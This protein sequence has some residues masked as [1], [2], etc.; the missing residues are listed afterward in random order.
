M[1][2]A[3][4]HWDVSRKRAVVDAVR[5][6]KP[7]FSPA[8]VVK[9]CADLLKPYRLSRVKGDRYGGE[10]PREAFREHRIEYYL[11]SKTKSELYGEMLPALNSGTIELLD[12]PRTNAQLSALERRVARGGRDTVDHPV[13]GHD[14]CI[15]AAAGSLIDAL[16]A[17]K[18]Q[19]E[20]FAPPDCSRATSNPGNPEVAPSAPAPSTIGRPANATR[21]N[22]QRPPAH[23]LKE[24]DFIGAMGADGYVS[25]AGVNW[26]PVSIWGRAPGS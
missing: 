6:F 21:I 23:Y 3:V 15:N 12:H 10:W 8:A 18:A 11:S 19:L 1:T 17:A 25:A 4:A 14:D 22:Q 13:G 26:G 2:I 24:S 5:E 16:A 9:E 20:F 7:P